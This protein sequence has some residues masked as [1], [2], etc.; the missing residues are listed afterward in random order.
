MS[1]KDNLKK[2]SFC[3]G[4]ALAQEEQERLRSAINVAKKVFKE[5]GWEGLTSEKIATATARVQ[6]LCPSVDWK[7]AVNA[8]MSEYYKD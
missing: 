8:A 1:I 2:M 6:L 4:H 3:Q 7:V 5:N